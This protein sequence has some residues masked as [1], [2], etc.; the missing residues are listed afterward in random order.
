ML[1]LIFLSSCSLYYLLY[2][3]LINLKNNKNSNILESIKKLYEVYSK[4]THKSL[5]LLT[6]GFIIFIFVSSLY[7]L[8]FILAPLSLNHSSYPYIFMRISL[9]PCIYIFNEILLKSIFNSFNSNK[10]KTD[11]SLLSKDRVKQ[12]N[13][14]NLITMGTCIYI[15]SELKL[16]YSHLLYLN[17]EHWNIRLKSENLD[18]LNIISTD[19]THLNNI[20]TINPKNTSKNIW[21]MLFGDNSY[22]SQFQPI[23]MPRVVEYN[24]VIYIDKILSNRVWYSITIFEGKVCLLLENNVHEELC[25]NIGERNLLNL[26]LKA[27]KKGIKLEEFISHQEDIVVFS[28]RQLPPIN[29]ILNDILSTPIPE[30]LVPR[31]DVPLDNPHNIPPL[32]VPGPIPAPIP[33]PIPSYTPYNNPYIPPVI[34]PPV[35]VL[36]SWEIDNG[37][38]MARHPMN[39]WHIPGHSHNLFLSILNKLTLQQQF[40]ASS[41]HLV[42][43]QR[44]IFNTQTFPGPAT[45]TIAEQEFIFSLV[46]RYHNTVFERYTLNWDKIS[47]HGPYSWY[48]R[49]RSH[50]G[51]Y[52]SSTTALQNIFRSL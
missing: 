35:V 39:S 1:L 48:F 28:G 21:C 12:F 29:D 42:P 13:I 25:F 40:I 8:E 30:S 7:L 19:K 27:P 32:V 47:T 22:P 44:Y 5:F 16:F 45:M 20:N 3:L 34:V 4:H 18:N 26:I 23:S 51:M 38:I 37:Q 46:A 9:S 52:V 2:C 31:P 50:N 10:I 36:H 41:G 14:Y 24:G 11:Y 15:G 33:A 49:M 6:L 43:G 17:I